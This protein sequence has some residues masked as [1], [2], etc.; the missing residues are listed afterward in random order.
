M[1]SSI[2]QMRSQLLS[3]RFGTSKPVLVLSFL[4]CSVCSAL[5]AH[6]EIVGGPS[7]VRYRAGVIASICTITATDG[8]LGASTNRS[9]ISSSAS[10]LSGGFFG[11]PTFAAIDVTSNM[12]ATGTLIA[13]T[14]TLTGPTAATTSQLRFRNLSFATN[15]TENLAADGSLKTTL[16]VRFDAPAGGF[17]NGTYTATAVVTCN[18]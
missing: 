13:T 4:L 15:A 18:Q 16:D 5:P 12:G 2:S 11:N 9:V 6:A 17:N 10:E 1:S 14:P 7:T 8:E 3:I